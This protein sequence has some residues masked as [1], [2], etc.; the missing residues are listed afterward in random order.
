[1]RLLVK[2]SVFAALGSSAL[3][4]SEYEALILQHAEEIFPGWRVVPFKTTIES[5]HG[6]RRPDLALVA[7]DLRQWWVV[8]VELAHH[9]MLDHVYPQVQAFASGDYGDAHAA[10]LHRHLK[11]IDL[12]SLRDMIRNYYPRVHVVVNQELPGWLSPLHEL[13]AT[14][15][16]VEIY[17]SDTEEYAM[18]VF[19]S[20]PGVF[21]TR[22]SYCERDKLVMNAF[23]VKN[24][25]LLS[26][27][28]GSFEIQV[29]GRITTWYRTDDSSQLI[30]PSGGD[31]FGDASDFFLIE[32]APNSYHAR[33]AQG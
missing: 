10:A 11:E 29:D 27:I 21:Q 6:S 2:D 32:D 24:S 33:P 14:L 3:R 22:R 20:T 17:R 5:P 18:R 30:F 1:M 13:D 23:R 15:S 25:E 12:S 31:P 7:P 9:P 16:V 4:E 28:S 8:E 19:G 26:E